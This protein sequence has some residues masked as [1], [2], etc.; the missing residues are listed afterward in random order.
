MWKSKTGTT[1]ILEIYF[2]VFIAHIHHPAR[3]TLTE[4]FIQRTTDHIYVDD[5]RHKLVRMRFDVVLGEP[6]SHQLTFPKGLH[7]APKYGITNGNLRA[8]PGSHQTIL[9]I[10]CYCTII[11]ISCI[12][13]QRLKQ[14]L[15]E[16]CETA[17]NRGQD[18]H[19][20]QL[21]AEVKASILEG[22]VKQCEKAVRGR[23]WLSV[24]PQSRIRDSYLTLANAFALRKK[25][26]RDDSNYSK[27]I[28]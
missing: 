6:S 23:W 2:T 19:V 11:I 18:A 20:A 17:R 13:L 26:P 22:R 21:A 16:T 1:S 4:A 3:T 12:H 8:G 28:T 5:L 14:E 10:R 7:G 25:F 9:H 24:V 15:Q 27:V